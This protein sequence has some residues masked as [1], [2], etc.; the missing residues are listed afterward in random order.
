MNGMEKMFG[1][2][3][4]GGWMGGSVGE[5]MP[6]KEEAPGAGMSCPVCGT[7]FAPVESEEAAGGPGEM[8]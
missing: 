1:D 4:G 6:P 8:E 3:R 2:M 5:P 7:K